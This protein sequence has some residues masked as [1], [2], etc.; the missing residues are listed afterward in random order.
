MQGD[1]RET[2]PGPDP[3]PL[4]DLGADTPAGDAGTKP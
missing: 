4:P 1:V 2:G 3:E